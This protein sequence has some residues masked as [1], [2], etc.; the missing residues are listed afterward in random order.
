MTVCCLGGRAFCAPGTSPAPE[1]R[2]V[3]DLLRKHLGGVSEADFNSNAV[4]GLVS[5]FAPRASLGKGPSGEES[6]AQFIA[7]VENFD[8]LACFRVSRVGTGLDE[9]LRKGFDAIGAS[10]RV[11]G[12]ALDLRFATGSEYAAAA[13]AADLFLNRE[14][15]LLDWGGGMT[16]S[17]ARTG[18]ITVPVAVLINGQ[19]SGAA[20]ALAAVLRDAGAAVLLG[21]K[22]AG[23]AG[24]MKEY[25]LSNGQV[26]RISTT[27][28]KLGSGEDLPAD[29]VKPDIEVKVRPEDE[30]I[31]HADAY[32]LAPLTNASSAFGTNLAAAG[33]NRTRRARFNEAA[34]VRERREGTAFD[35]DS[36]AEPP[37]EPERVMVADPVLARALDLLKGL[38]LVRPRS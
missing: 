3:Y 32:S 20:E 11:R 37:D 27:A 26:L 7:R 36:A 25:P 12:V 29:G 33:T 13:E 15:P 1:F 14:R 10:N 8:G 24:I 6:S 23:Q 28:V 22:T 38:A 5:A 2:E 34:L 16:R 30:R 9:A 4:R 31:Y 18:A 21:G 17:K 35:S 19:T